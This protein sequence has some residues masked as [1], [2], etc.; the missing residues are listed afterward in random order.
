MSLFYCGDEDWTLL[1]VWPHQWSEQRG[2]ITLLGLLY[3]AMIMIRIPI[4][5]FMARAYCWLVFLCVH[6]DSQVPFCKAAFQLRGTQPVLIHEFIPSWDQVFSF[7]VELYEVIISPFLQPVKV[8]L[9]GSMI[10][11]HISC[12]I[13]QQT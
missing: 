3:L 7:L 9:D 6:Q 1:Q 11:W 13:Y 10:L 5:F 8:L 2:R 12:F 4:T